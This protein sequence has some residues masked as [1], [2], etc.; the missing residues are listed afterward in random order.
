MA[1]KT[2]L[3]NHPLTNQVKSGEVS[4]PDLNFEFV[5]EPVPNKAFKRVVAC[6]EFDLAELAIVTFFQAKALGKPLTLLPIPV[7]GRSQQGL[8][9]TRRN[10]AINT[11]ADLRGAKIGARSAAQTSVVWLRGYLNDECGHGYQDASWLSYEQAHITED[12]SSINFSSAP[13]QAHLLNDLLDGRIDAALLNPA[14]TQHPDLKQVISEPE[15]KAKTWE[16]SKG[17]SQ[18][19]HV[20]VIRQ[21]VLTQQPN[22]AESLT[23]LFKQSYEHAIQKQ[24]SLAL[25]FG[26]NSLSPSLQQ[27]LKY[28]YEQGLLKRNISIES[29]F[30]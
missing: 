9:M 26:Q 19:N 22:V 30:I 13:N 5:D 21:D 2:L 23:G 6:N 16:A 7:M 18:V 27:L 12:L 17:I 11:V 3:G 28:S 20:L 1:L 4:H 15:L 14:D 8:L 10:S 25:P 24:P 29:L